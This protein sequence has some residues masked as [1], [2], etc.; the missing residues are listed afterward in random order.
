[1]QKTTYVKSITE[2]NFIK[3]LLN[4]LSKNNIKHFNVADLENFLF[5]YVFEK[6]FNF[7]FLNK[8]KNLDI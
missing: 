2:V 5:K 6:G 4:E 3:I 8:K 7:I 1:M